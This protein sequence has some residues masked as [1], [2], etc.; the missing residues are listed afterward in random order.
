MQLSQRKTIP[1][2]SVV[3]RAF[4]F[5]TFTPSCFA[6]ATISILFLDETACEIL[7][8]VS[9]NYPSTK[10]FHLLCGIG[11]VVHEEKI[12]VAGVVDEECLVA[13]GHHVAGLLVGAK[14]NLCGLIS[15]CPSYTCNS[16]GG[17]LYSRSL[18]SCTTMNLLCTGSNVPKA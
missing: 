1:Q 3:T 5:V 2:T 14:T 17:Q 15:D 4:A 16:H 6:R 8:R 9:P 10:V 7:N 12:N 13:G 18:N 11:L